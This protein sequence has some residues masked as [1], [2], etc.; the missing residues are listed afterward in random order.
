MPP[1]TADWVAAAAA[2]MAVGT[3][4][5]AIL[6]IF[7]VRSRARNEDARRWEE[8]QRDQ[9]ME[10]ASVI[11]H[12]LQAAVA[13]SDDL[14]SQLRLLR[15]LIS[16]ASNIADQVYFRL[17]P[18]VSAA[19]LQSALAE[20]RNFRATVCV[21]GWNASPQ[22]KALEGVR[23]ELREAGL[24]LSGQLTLVTR[25]AELYDDMI[26]AGC[27]PDVFQEALGNELLMRMFCDEHRSQKD[28]RALINALASHLQVESTSN[29]KAH[30]KLSV[31]Y[32]SDFIKIAGNEF[33]GWSDEKLVAASANE[34]PAALDSSTKIGYIQTVLIDLRPDIHGPQ[35][36]DVM[37]LLVG[38]ID[39][40]NAAR[41]DTA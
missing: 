3:A 29:F 25:A 38:C 28:S 6:M 15:P 17:G 30:I 13:Y 19:D 10:K 20:D 24:Q 23:A 12:N 39:A 27:S 35:I 21:S 26:Q 16:G 5:L 37:A 2:F 32:L 11:R 18:N 8:S 9:L 33:I 4:I 34:N 22:T 40:F 7:L 31:E 41:R 36:F 14:A 1:N